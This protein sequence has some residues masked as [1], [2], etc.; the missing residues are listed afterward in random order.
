MLDSP[1]LNLVLEIL[2]K[3]RRDKELVVLSGGL[4]D[5]TADSLIAN[6][7]RS[8]GVIEGLSF[9]ERYIDSLKTTEEEDDHE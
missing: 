6:Y 3:E 2:E 8:I 1:E 4:S 9:L 7:N 5:G